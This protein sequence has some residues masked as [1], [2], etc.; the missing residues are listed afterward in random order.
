[1]PEAFTAFTGK[2]TRCCRSPTRST[3]SGSRA[4]K[5]KDKPLTSI[6]RG[7]VKFGFDNDRKEA[8]EALDDGNRT[9]SRRA[10]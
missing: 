5:F 9:R 2:G 10:Q 8:V 7:E 6:R 3:N 4:P 1:L